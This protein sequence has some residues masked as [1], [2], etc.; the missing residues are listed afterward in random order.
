[1]VILLKELKHIASVLRREHKYAYG[2]REECHRGE[3]S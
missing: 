3:H 2:L 1:M